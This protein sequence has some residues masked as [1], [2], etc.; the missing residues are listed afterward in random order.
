MQYTYYL[1]E[2]PLDIGTYP[3]KPTYLSGEG[4]DKKLY[5]MSIDR[6]AWGWVS[7]SEPLTAEEVKQ[8]ELVEL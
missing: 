1:T 2:R 7:Y 5:I 8:Y 4:F 3:K 6:Y